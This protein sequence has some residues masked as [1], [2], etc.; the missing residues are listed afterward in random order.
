MNPKIFVGVV[1]IVF[2]VI[3]GTIVS[4]GPSLIDDTSEGGSLFTPFNKGQIEI[5]PLEIELEDLSVLSVSD[6]DAT[7]QIKF[8]VSNP[9][10]KSAILTILKYELYENGIRITGGQIGE[11]PEGMMVTG[12]TY[13]TILNDNPTVLT[14]KI[15]IKNSGNM[16]EFWSALLTDTLTWK[17]KGTA[18]SN[19]SSMTSGGENETTFEFFR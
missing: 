1:V 5:L 12:S 2:A 10:F 8:K 9:N 7:L 16:P 19:L 3:I 18:F 4:S 14:D 15:T 13:F 6:D 11:R 17:I